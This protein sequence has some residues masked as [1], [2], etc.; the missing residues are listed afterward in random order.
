MLAAK[1][2]LEVECENL[3]ARLKMVEVSQTASELNV[4]ESRLGRAKE[5]VAELRSRLQ[6]AEKLVGSE[7]T[8]QGEIQLDEAGTEDIVD[9]VAEYFDGEAPAAQPVVVAK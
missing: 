5:L 6:V 4:D 8:F 9:Q 2:Q 1:R 3:D 7:S